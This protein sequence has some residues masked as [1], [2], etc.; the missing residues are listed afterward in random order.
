MKFTFTKC[1]S[2]RRRWMRRES[3]LPR[4]VKCDCPPALTKLMHDR[5]T[6]LNNSGTEVD[7]NSTNALHTHGLMHTVSTQSTFLL[8][9]E[10]LSSSI[11]VK[12][13][14]HNNCTTCYCLTRDWWVRCLLGNPSAHVFECQIRRVA[15]SAAQSHCTCSKYQTR[16]SASEA[17]AL[18]VQSCVLLFPIDVSCL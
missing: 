14:R 2:Q 15:C 7:K 12:W 11:Q 18:R 16:A 13:C 1:H 8:L 17:N 5:Q 3:R 4:S 6:F 9:K 10:R